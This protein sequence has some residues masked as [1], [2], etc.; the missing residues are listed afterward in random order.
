MGQNRLVASVEKVL[1]EAARRVRLLGAV[2][3]EEAAEERA[4]LVHAFER[5]DGA[6][7]RWSYATVDYADLLQ[8]LAA[9]EKELEAA[10]AGDEAPLA[11]VYL[12]RA[13]E[14]A[15]E[16]AM[17]EVAGTRRLGELARLR[18]APGVEAAEAARLAEAWLGARAPEQGGAKAEAPETRAAGAAVAAE[19]DEGNVVLAS[20]AD[21]PRSLLSRMRAEVGRR[22]LPFSVVAHAALAP[23]AATGERTILVARGRTLTDEDAR[24]TVLHEIEGHALPRV[25]ARRASA[26]IFAFGTARGADDQEGRA[27]LLEERAGFLGTRRKRQLAARHRTVERMLEGASFVEAARALSRSDGFSA[28]DAVLVAERVY[29]GGDGVMPGLGRERIYLESLVRVR[30]ALESRPEDEAVMAAGQVAAGAVDAL[31]AYAPPPAQS[32]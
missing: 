26:G 7:P 12:E 9:A 31:R 18:F 21:D 3:P 2:T 17:A 23:L 25:H 10:A 24:R 29:R 4:R 22:F 11:R 30:R 27:L 5:G 16:A 20:D 8:A 13:R 19:R 15:M 1:A 6:A 14:L 28:H 32:A